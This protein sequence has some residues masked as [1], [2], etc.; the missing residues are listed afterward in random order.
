M[1]TSYCR[2]VL[3]K[4]N[5]SHAVKGNEVTLEYISERF[6]LFKQMT[7]FG[8][9]TEITLA[10]YDDSYS[11]NHLGCMILSMSKRYL[12]KV[13]DLCEI[14][15]INVYY[16]DTDSMHIDKDKVSILAAA[17]LHKY[18]EQ[19]IGKQLGQFHCDFKIS[20]GH[21]ATAYSRYCLIVGPK[22]Y[23]DDVVCDICNVNNE[24][25]RCK[26]IPTNCVQAICQHCNCN[27]QEI[28]ERLC[29]SPVT[30]N[31][32]PPGTSRMCIKIT[33]VYNIPENTFTRT[34]CFA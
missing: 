12:H 31:L 8:N 19:F 27:V 1:N 32:N 24:H 28:F 3:K 6:G 11:R 2:L 26:G 17:Y 14:L 5:E 21:N 34:L 4:T 15:Q 23:F 20:C 10:K 29:H 22:V 18:N 16:I 13:L 9:H 7:Q 30:F 25:Y 33:G